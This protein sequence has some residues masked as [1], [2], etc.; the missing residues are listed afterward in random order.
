MFLLEVN[1]NWQFCQCGQGR[2]DFWRDYEPEYENKTH[3]TTLITKE[4][5][6]VIRKHANTKKENLAPNAMFLY[7]AYND[8]H[9]PLLT[10]PEFDGHCNHIPNRYL[11][12]L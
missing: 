12:I 2:Y 10:D 6:N 5:V 7:I 11:T 3:A 8:P 4:S 1:R 9:D